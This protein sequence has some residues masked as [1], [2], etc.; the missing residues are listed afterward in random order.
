M[1]RP[2][3]TRLD[4]AAA[5]RGTVFHRVVVGVDDSSEALEAARQ[6]AM[7]RDFDGEVTIVS[8]WELPPPLASGSILYDREAGTDA[9]ARLE[10]DES[11]LRACRHVGDLAS[12]RPKVVRGF[13]TQ[14]L[15]D[16]ATATRASL[17]AVGSHGQGR[18]A[19]I[20]AAST[21][22]EVIHRAPC[23]VLVAR[24]TGRDSP[25]RIV[26]GIDGSPQSA[27]AY[28]TAWSLA[29]RFGAELL[30]VVAHGGKKVDMRLVS[31]LVDH[32]HADLPAE[33]VS[34]LVGAAADADLLVVGSRG[35][36][37]FK[38][39]GSVSERVAHKAP[40]STLIVR[41]AP[42]DES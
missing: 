39:L 36:H 26:V 17:I 1:T 12:P 34:A 32:R 4:G 8:A 18:I 25:R 38:A 9:P 30:P 14:V 6:A 2:T 19:G 21:A 29:D 37:G 11:V 22:T 31:L 16:E 5:S 10:A 27:A 20:V 3:D 15:I 7:L 33:P 40:C 13:L 28:A 35:L 41:Q 24:A 42:W 23:S